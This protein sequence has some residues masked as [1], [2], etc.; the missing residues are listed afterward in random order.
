MTVDGADFLT[1]T[2]KSDSSSRYYVPADMGSPSNPQ[3]FGFALSMSTPSFSVVGT[4]CTTCNGASPY[5]QS[6][7][8]TASSLGGNGSFTLLGGGSTSGQLIKEDCQLPTDN[9]SLW[10]YPGQTI[11]V[12]NKSTSLYN[13][14]V[15]GI[16]GLQTGAGDPSLL[17]ASVLG[18][19]FSR[20]Q[21]KPSFTYGMALQPP[22][23]G[24]P[25]AGELHWTGPDP[26]AYTGQVSWKNTTPS[27]S[28]FSNTGGAG[29]PITVFSLD[30][31]KV[32]F[33][34]S[35]VQSSSQNLSAAL[36]PYYTDLY[37]P[38]S[39]AQLIYDKISQSSS[40][41]GDNGQSTLWTIPCGTTFSLDLTIGT[42]SFGL[43]QSQLTVTNADG[44]CTSRIRGW[45]DATNEQYL[46]G[47]S[48]MSSVYVIV[49]VANP[50][51]GQ[52]DMVGIAMRSTKSSTPVGAIVGGTVGGVAGLLI[53]GAVVFLL[54]RRRRKSRVV[55]EHD[56][57]DVHGNV[58]TYV[59][60][61][62]PIQPFPFASEGQA[63]PAHEPL[64][65]PSY[66]QTVQHIV[67]R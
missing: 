24:S 11:I 51:S 67:A 34:G 21:S 19:I 38:S 1:V 8:T 64:L 33:Q 29:S 49:Q 62:K 39:Q 40:A 48:F 66:D 23:V 41:S 3:K 59:D 37:F 30:M 53:I 17:N 47:S 27:T 20:N 63:T 54:V 60:D 35:T 28:S 50:S 58:G 15:S 10:A 43:D 6:K 65:P 9:G 45:T 56:R 36:D 61:T 57:E 12:T 7:S 13:N 52:S 25:N 26:L 32:Q 18:G 16:F 14:Q 5:N 44:T 55:G 22:S 42:V 46:F 31:W 4:V 2:L